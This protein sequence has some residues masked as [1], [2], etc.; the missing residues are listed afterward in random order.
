MLAGGGERRVDGIRNSLV[1]EKGGKEVTD[2]SAV[3]FYSI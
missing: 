3:N 2:L 1:N